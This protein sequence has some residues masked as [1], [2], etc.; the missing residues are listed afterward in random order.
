MRTTGVFYFVSIIL[1]SLGWVTNNSDYDT[2]AAIVML[3]GFILEPP[4]H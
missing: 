2:L 1:I 3:L 4:L